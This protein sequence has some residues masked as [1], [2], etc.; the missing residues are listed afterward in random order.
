MTFF[1][2]FF[3]FFTLRS[4]PAI[5]RSSQA[6]GQIGA[7]AAGLCHNHSNEGSKPDLQP[8][9]QLTEMPDP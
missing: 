5:Y 6:R 2:L 3:F 1:F 7:A 4:T 9:S 8:T